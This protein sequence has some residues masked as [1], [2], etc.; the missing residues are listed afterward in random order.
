MSATNRWWECLC[1]TERPK[2]PD[3]PTPIRTI[4]TLREPRCPFC[5]HAYRKEYERQDNDS[6]QN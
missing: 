4:V 3:G 1:G 2:H 6:K 5:G